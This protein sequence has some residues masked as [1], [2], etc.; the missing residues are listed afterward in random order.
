MQDC[1]RKHPEIYGTEI[2]EMGD[3]EAEDAA[4]APSDAALAED[5][6]KSL[7]VEETSPRK[8][9]TATELVKV[10]TAPATEPKAAQPEA[11]QPEEPKDSTKEP[12]IPAKAHDA[13]EAN[14]TKDQ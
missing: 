7:P 1:F 6:P 2:S 14:K 11:A 3:D 12:E 5:A 4:T 10:E 13:T 9:E 8:P